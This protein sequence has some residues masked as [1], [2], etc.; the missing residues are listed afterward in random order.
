MVSTFIQPFGSDS[1]W[2]NL[3]TSPAPDFNVAVVGFWASDA[4]M[5]TPIGCLGWDPGLI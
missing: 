4:V 5:S 2:L 3:W 1:S